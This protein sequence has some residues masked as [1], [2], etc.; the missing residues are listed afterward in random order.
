MGFG[1]TLRLSLAN[2]LVIVC[3]LFSISRPYSGSSV[4][5][6]SPDWLIV[7]AALG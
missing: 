1:Y 2:L 4:V 5:Y 7:S 6:N 3:N